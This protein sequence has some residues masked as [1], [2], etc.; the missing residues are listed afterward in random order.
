MGR[1]NLG[2]NL[3]N[4]LRSAHALR[5]RRNWRCARYLSPPWIIRADLLLVPLAK[6]PFSTKTTLSPRMAASLAIPA[7]VI[8]PP[9][10]MTSNG[11]PFICSRFASLTAAENSIDSPYS[12]SRVGHPAQASHR[13]LAGCA[14]KRRMDENSFRLDLSC[15]LSETEIQPMMITCAGWCHCRKDL[16]DSS[17]LRR[18]STSQLTLPNCTYQTETVK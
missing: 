11:P 15:T 16:P 9:I 5:T 6:S 17:S 4:L 12:A 13:R 18:A 10:T 14:L 7:P 8:P 1:T 2:A 3:P